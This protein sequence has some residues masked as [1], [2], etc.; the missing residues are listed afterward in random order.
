MWKS[1][2]MALLIMSLLIFVGF[3]FFYSSNSILPTEE[4]AVPIR[5]YDT[6]TGLE[7][8]VTIHSSQTNPSFT[9]TS[10]I[11]ESIFH[12]KSIDTI[13]DFEIHLIIDNK[14][15]SNYLLEGIKIIDKRNHDVIEKVSYQKDSSSNSFSF[16]LPKSF[17]EKYQSYYSIEIDFSR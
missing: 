8:Y 15:L 14:S 2:F 1:Y 4:E 13:D 9:V 12:Y 5:E 7:Y 6:I 16:L 3:S 17:F 10:H 11:L